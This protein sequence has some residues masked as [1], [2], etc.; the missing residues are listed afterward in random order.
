M[1]YELRGSRHLDL[2]DEEAI[3]LLA[4]EF[5]VSEQAIAIRLVNLGMLR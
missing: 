5:Y 2:D 1:F 3:R 4:K